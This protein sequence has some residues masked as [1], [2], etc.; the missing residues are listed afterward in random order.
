MKV[1]EVRGVRFMFWAEGMTLYPF[2]LY[3]PSVPSRELMR[4]E[5]IHVEQVRRDG[6]IKFYATYL[7]DWAKGII[8][9][10]SFGRAYLGIP[11]EIAAYARQN[12]GGPIY[13]A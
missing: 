11:Y 1:I 2:V 6:W 3:R 10:K 8:R 12:D 9:Y 4:H 7:W 5:S 13:D